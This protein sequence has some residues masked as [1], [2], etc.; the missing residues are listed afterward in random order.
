MKRSIESVG[1]FATDPCQKQ[2]GPTPHISRPHSG[3]CTLAARAWLASRPDVKRYSALNE[4]LASE[5]GRSGWPLAYWTAELL[6]SIRARKA[7]V[8][9]DRK[10]L[11]F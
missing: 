5:L 10:P 9:P 11:P 1:V 3:C 8:E 2:S 4:L 6:F 7:W